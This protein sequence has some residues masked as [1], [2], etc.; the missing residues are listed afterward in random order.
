MSYKEQSF[1]R[2][3]AIATWRCLNPKPLDAAEARNAEES[4]RVERFCREL[5]KIAGE[6]FDIDVTVNGG[7]LEAIIDDLRFVA[8]E[9]TPTGEVHYTV[10][11]VLG[12]CPSCGVE[13][14]SE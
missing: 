2:T 1:I 8:Y 3:L 4:K 13:V 14:I 11:T 6:N 10:L 5:R 9:V 12:R 7:C